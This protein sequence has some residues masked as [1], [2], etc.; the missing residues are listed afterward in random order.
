[1]NLIVDLNNMA[2][3]TRYSKLGMPKSR[4]QKDK[5]AELLIFIEAMKLI[6]GSA[7]KF[8]VDGIVIAKDSKKVWRKDIYPE[9]KGTSTSDEDFYYDETIYAANMVY[10]FFRDYTSAYCLEVPKTEADDIIAVWC[11]N[12]TEETVILSSDKDYI[13][14][15]DDR[16]RLYSPTQKVFRESVDSGY[17]LFLKCI[18]GDKSDNIK[19]AYPRLRETKIKKAWED[20]LEMLNLLETVIEDVKVGDKVSFNQQL[21]DLTMQ[22]DEIRDSILFEIKNYKSNKYSQIKVLKYMKENRLD[23][24]S[25]I[26]DHKE[27]PLKQS[28][29]FLK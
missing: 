22:P 13:Q 4:R 24:F 27:K 21:M 23:K 15:I 25:N 11:Q 29:I 12:T 5:D 26:F 9:Y 28:P 3:I 18:R 6:L 2:F 14:L 7:T 19:S 10:S 16:T 1:M 17:E 8:N 20:D